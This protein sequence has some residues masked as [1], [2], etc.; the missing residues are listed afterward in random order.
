MGIEPWPQ[1]GKGYTAAP[2]SRFSTQ[3][4]QQQTVNP[5][6]NP[7][8]FARTAV[9]GHVTPRAVWIAT[10]SPAHGLGPTIDIDG[11][12]IVTAIGASAP[13]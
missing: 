10:G 1:G 2:M 12:R 7:P 13:V 4:F 6:S 8:Q 11:V 5:P 9:S 3:P